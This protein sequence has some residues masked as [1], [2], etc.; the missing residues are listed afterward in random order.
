MGL[1]LLPIARKG[2]TRREAADLL[3]G[4]A[5]L[6]ENYPADAVVLTLEIE[7]VTTADRQKSKGDPAPTRKKRA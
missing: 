5:A 6:L 7:V 4:L 2:L 3:N 1:P